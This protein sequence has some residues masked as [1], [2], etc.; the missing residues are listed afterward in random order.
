MTCEDIATELTGFAGAFSMIT[1]NFARQ[2]TKKQSTEYELLAY[3]S[4]ILGVAKAPCTLLMNI[5]MCIIIGHN[6]QA[7]LLKYAAKHAE[8]SK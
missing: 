7:I 8:T 2:Q 1:R 5:R 6:T 3:R 4:H